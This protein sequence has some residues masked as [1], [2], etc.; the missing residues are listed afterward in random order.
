[1]P[2]LLGLL[3]YSSFLLSRYFSRGVAEQTEQRG[4]QG[5]GKG[6]EQLWTMSL[7]LWC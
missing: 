1:M 7:V 5:G 6:D 2:K 3:M 4:D